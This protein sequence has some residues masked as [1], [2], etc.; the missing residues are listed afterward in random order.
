MQGEYVSMR[1]AARIMGVTRQRMHQLLKADRIPGAVRMYAGSQR[2]L[3][4][5]PKGSIKP[6]QIE[7]Q[8]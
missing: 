8:K 5:I 7:E 4:V 1:E 3:W 6:A 2:Y